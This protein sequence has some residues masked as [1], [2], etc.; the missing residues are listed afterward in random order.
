MKFLDAKNYFEE[1]NVVVD[2][3]KIEFEVFFR[4]NISVENGV[5]FLY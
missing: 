1:K 5:G 3:L 2:K 4:S